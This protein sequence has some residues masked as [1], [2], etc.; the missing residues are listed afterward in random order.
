VKT[1]EIKPLLAGAKPNDVRLIRVL[2]HT[3]L[4]G[5][6]GE[7]AAKGGFAGIGSARNIERLVAQAA[8]KG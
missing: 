4:G 1:Q 3:A 6:Q 2:R 7:P 5:N 8:D